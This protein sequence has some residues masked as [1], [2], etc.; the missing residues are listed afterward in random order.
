MEG[1]SFGDWLT[2]LI[3]VAGFAVSIVGGIWYLAEWMNREFSKNR[4]LIFDKIEELK[5]M[6]I[7]KLEYH[8]RHDDSR[9]SEIKDDLWAIKLR[10]AARDGMI[11]NREFVLDQENK[12]NIRR[13]SSK[14]TV[15]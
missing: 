15:G 13:A 11:L 1:P 6:F 10:N 14:K 3:F 5:D 9:F 8:E 2:I 4:G 7:S 12:T